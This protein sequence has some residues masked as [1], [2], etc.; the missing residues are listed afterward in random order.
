[1]T[2]VV[3]EVVVL[4]VVYSEQEGVDIASGDTISEESCE[5]VAVMVTTT[6]E[7]VS[8]SVT[9]IVANNVDN[10]VSVTAGSVDAGS[11]TVV[12]AAVLVGP[13]STGTTEYVA[14]LRSPPGLGRKGRASASVMRV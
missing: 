11:V 1:V 14:F 5:G 12:T 13:P 4:V 8:Y 6:V 3:G 9:T 2:W 7:G 10:F